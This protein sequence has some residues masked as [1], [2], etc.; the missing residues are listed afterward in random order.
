MG[1]AMAGCLTRVAFGWRKWHVWGCGWGSTVLDANS[2]AWCPRNGVLF[3]WGGAV[4]L[5]PPTWDVFSLRY[6]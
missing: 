4:W 2:G 6:I 1:V 5:T 3:F